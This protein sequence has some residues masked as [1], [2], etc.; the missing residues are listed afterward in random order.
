[1]PRWNIDS[2]SSE[3]EEHSLHKAKYR[4][5]LPQTHVQEQE[6]PQEVQQQQQDYP[7][8]QPSFPQHTPDQSDSSEEQ[9]H[10]VTQDESDHE[11]QEKEDQEEKDDDEEEEEE[12]EEEEQVEDEGEDN[13]ELL[14][15]DE[16]NV[17]L[18]V[19]NPP[20]LDHQPEDEEDDE[21]Y[22][23]EEEEEEEEIDVSSFKYKLQKYSEA[24]IVN[25]NDHKVSKKASSAF[26]NIARKWMFDLTTAF[27]NEKKKKFPKF[28]HI[29][30]KLVKKN[31][32]EVSMDIGY[33]HKKTNKLTIVK[34]T[35]KVPVKK[36]PTDTYEK[37]FEIASIKVI[38][39]ILILSMFLASRLILFSLSL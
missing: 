35:Q 29:R 25:E 3:L 7:Q 6:T 2:E 38:K 26:W 10:E 11:T 27:K 9:L 24:W 15:S 21:D 4:P 16:E 19:I 33:V 20:T 14:A 18:D 32:P 12:E 37:V 13:L 31:V 39:I 22:E 30:R 1:M 5:G 23:S 8:Q 36:F 17:P 34:D 28:E